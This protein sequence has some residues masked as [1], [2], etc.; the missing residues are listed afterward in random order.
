[1]LILGALAALTFGLALAGCAGESRTPDDLVAEGYSITVTIDFNGGRSAGGKNSIVQYVRENGLV[2]E[3]GT[4]GQLS[5]SKPT[6]DGYTF[7]G[8]FYPA[9][10]DEGNVIKDA[11]GLVVC[12]EPWNFSADRVTEDTTIYVDWLKNY[13]LLLHYGEDYAKSQSFTI[14]QNAEGVAQQVTEP[15]L[16]NDTI[17]D[18][19]ESREA[20][21]AAVEGTAVQFPFVPEGLSQENLTYELWANTLEGSWAIVRTADD[22]N[23]VYEGTNVYLM[24]DIDFG[25]E[26]VSLPFLDGYM[27]E[28]AGNGYTI[29]NFAIEREAAN[30]RDRSFGLFKELSS[31]ANVHDVSFEGV[32]FTAKLSNPMVTEYYAG[33]LAGRANSGVTVKNVSIAGSFTFE[34]TDSKYEDTE[35]GSLFGYAASEG[36]VTENCDI[37]QVNVTKQPAA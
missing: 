4:A 17:I 19:Y 5:G 29:S 36:V 1:M 12:G 7:R 18:V 34:I 24:N 26:T 13:S 27:A 16:V 37:S 30:N 2:V 14:T 8:Y 15:S 35:V 11:D 23:S 22:F 28:F 21:E 31:G 33:V 10:D 32:Q 9:L 25:G 20:A 6:R 3:P